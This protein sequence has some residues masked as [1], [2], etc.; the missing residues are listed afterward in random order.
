MSSFII[1]VS[2]G[3]LMI[4]SNPDLCDPQ[5]LIDQLK[6]QNYEVRANAARALGKLG[7]MPNAAI[8]SLAGAIKDEQPTVRI[9]AAWAIG[10]VGKRAVPFL[11]P[12]L[13]DGEPHV[14][15]LSCSALGRIGREAKAALPM[16]KRMLKDSNVANRLFAADAMMKIGGKNARAIKTLTGFIRAADPNLRL[17]SLDSLANAGVCPPEGVRVLV[18]MI[19][20][21]VHRDADFGVFVRAC[22]VLARMGKGARDYLPALEKIVV[23]Y[24]KEKVIQS[25][26]GGAIVGINPN[27]RIGRAAVK[28]GLTEISQ[29]LEAQDEGILILLCNSVGS[30]GRAGRAALPF[31]RKLCASDNQKIRAAARNAIRRIGKKGREKGG[32]KGDR[33]KRGK[34]DM[35]YCPKGKIRE[36]KWENQRGQGLRQEAQ[37]RGKRWTEPLGNLSS[38]PYG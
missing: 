30:L 27:S 1:L 24:P 34:P 20:N 5:A 4:W 10:S 9:A 11:E 33:G 8:P 7:S 17:L 29:Y 35:P 32:G 14:R 2:A 23:A 37:E 15:R 13:K 26:V 18:K 28:G 36:N 38:E 31:V 12:L 16:L 19:E 22:C 6:S 3:L 21:C 25:I